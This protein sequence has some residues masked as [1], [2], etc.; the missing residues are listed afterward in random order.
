[1]K[2]NLSFIPTEDYFTLKAVN[3]LCLFS[4]PMKKNEKKLQEPLAMLLIGTEK[5]QSG[6]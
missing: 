2:D 6:F 1:M 4:A 5:R 3:S